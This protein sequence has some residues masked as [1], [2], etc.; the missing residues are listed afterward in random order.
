[1]PESTDKLFLGPLSLIAFSAIALFLSQIEA[2]LVKYVFKKRLL[3]E[4]PAKPLKTLEKKSSCTRVISLPILDKPL[5]NLSCS[6]WD[7]FWICII[8]A[9]PIFLNAEFTS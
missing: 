8:L 6:P 9:S 7:N 1:M 3:L 4:K 2:S 5:K